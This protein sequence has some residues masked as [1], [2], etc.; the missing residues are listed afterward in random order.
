MKNI[1]KDTVFLAIVACFLW[2]TAF[3]AV[4]IGL[5]YQ[6][7]LQFAAIRFFISGVLI[8]L[9]FGN[10]K[11]IITEV[12]ANLRFVLVVS[13]LQI[14]LQYAFF[15]TGIN[16][17]P[18]ALGSMIVGSS[19]L[20]IAVVAHFLVHND[21]LTWLKMVSIFFG[22]AGIA[23]ITLGRTTIEFKNKYEWV[24]IG[25]LLFNN[26]MSGYANVR[27]M[28]DKSGISPFVLSSASLII[29]SIMLFVVSLPVEGIHFRALPATYFYALAWLGFLS[30]AAYTIWYSLLKRPGIKVSNLNIWKF[31]IPVSGAILSWL[32]VPGEKPDVISLSGMGVIAVALVM[33]GFSNRK[34]KTRDV[35]SVS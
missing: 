26:I 24:G 2:S 19:P 7:P 22:V 9:W 30:A 35:I 8:M 1:L 31:L 27:I 16:L 25:L 33:L 10:Y 6:P 3:A 14:F 28:K 23:I 13:L 29:G 21:K 15:Y 34:S 20:F 11:Q 4:K 5:Q 32:L 18:A 12:K 17:I